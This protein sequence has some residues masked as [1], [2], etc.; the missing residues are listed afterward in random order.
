MRA[1]SK[2]YHIECFRC[3]ACHR[4]LVPGDEFALRD[5]G[6]L[7]KDDHDVN[8]NNNS[9]SNNS[10]SNNSSVASLLLMDTK[11]ESNGSATSAAAVVAAAAAV[12]TT[13]TGATTKSNNNNSLSVN[14]NISNSSMV[15]CSAD[16]R[17]SRANSNDSHSGKFPPFCCCG[18]CGGCG[19]PR[20]FVGYAV[21]RS[22]ARDCGR[23]VRR[24]CC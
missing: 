10:S 2:I 19:H 8:T 9:S 17:H 24:C 18:C 13:P 3:T 6:L 14:H 20:G 22:G 7:C 12:G 1:K 23:V 4:Q 21:F 5:D 11:T 15:G 16:G